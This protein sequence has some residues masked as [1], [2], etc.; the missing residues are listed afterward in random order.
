[1]HQ[2]CLYVSGEGDAGEYAETEIK[3]EPLDNG[4]YGGVQQNGEAVAEQEATTAAAAEPEMA[5]N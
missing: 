5:A 1:M 4:E 2:V 3:E